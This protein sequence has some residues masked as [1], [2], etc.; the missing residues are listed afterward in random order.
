MLFWKR[1]RLARVDRGFTLVAVGITLV[2]VAAFVDYS[3]VVIANLD[4]RAII[5][6]SFWKNSGTILPS[7][8]YFPGLV[9]AGF[10]LSSWL[11]AIQRLDREIDRREKLE[12]ELRALTENSERL[13]RDADKANQA[14]SEFLSNMSHELRT[15]LNAV[16]GFSEAMGEGIYGPINDL[17][18]HTI[19]DIREAGL[20]LLDLIN[21][22]LDLAK[23]EAGKFEPRFEEVNMERA[24]ERALRLLTDRAKRENIQIL[25]QLPANLPA[26]IADERLL[27]QM[28]INLLSNAIKFTPAGGSAIV[29]ISI[30]DDGGMHVEVRDTG[31]GIDA[32]DIPRAL[33][34]FG[35][36]DSS[37]GR[38]YQGTGLGLPLVKLFMEQHG[39][40][41]EIESEIGVGTTARLLFPANKAERSSQQI[42]G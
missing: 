29:A 34:A 19:A 8:L 41:L 13:A 17:Q 36:I 21:D 7:L 18:K 20:L 15:P 31:I 4:I 32:A 12:R 40:K 3:L 28:L 10:G 23:I 14:K 33:T 37:M 1:E 42:P 38:R 6:S 16:I 27:K 5:E 35:Q 26:L 30:P 11:P 25:T 2:A 39:G 22:I 24:I 9:I